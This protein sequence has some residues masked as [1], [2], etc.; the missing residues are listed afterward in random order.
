MAVLLIPTTPSVP[1]QTSKV[2]LEGRDFVLELRW[3]QR[4]S[5]WYLSI[6]DEA[7]IP[8]LMGV[9]LVANWE[10]LYAYRSEPGLPP[11]RLA[12]VDLTNDGSPPGFDEL[13]VGKRVELT[14]VEST[15]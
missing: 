7:S 10:L 4:E 13:G 1:F 11:G 6:F 12:A 3:N 9:K 15:T 8:L 5:R 2:R 14:Y